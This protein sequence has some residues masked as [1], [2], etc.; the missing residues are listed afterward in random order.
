MPLKRNAEW[1]ASRAAAYQRKAFLLNYQAYQK[2]IDECLKK[3]PEAIPRVREMLVQLKLLPPASANDPIQKPSLATVSEE[4]NLLAKV[5]NEEV[6]LKFPSR[7]KFLYNPGRAGESAPRH[8]LM[9]ILSQ[10]EPRVFSHHALKALAPAA[11]KQVPPQDLATLIEFVCDYATDVPLAAE[12]REVQAMIDA[13]KAAYVRCGEKA[14]HITLPPN[15]EQQGVYRWR[16]DP[17]M[18]FRGS[19]ELY[20]EKVSLTVDPAALSLPPET[21]LETLTLSSNWST[22]KAMLT[23][24][25][26]QWNCARLMV[27]LKERPVPPMLENGDV[28][29]VQE[30]EDRDAAMGEDFQ[31]EADMQPPP[32]A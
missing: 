24:G 12:H 32:P 2:E 6:P 3:H 11:R 4:E 22:D 20:H 23:S 10:V 31:D 7:V 27:S 18:P 14:Q 1:A 19:L 5:G 26:R 21:S 16:F 17:E 28:D 9:Y 25:L 29:S 13:L 30:E 8:V 15:W